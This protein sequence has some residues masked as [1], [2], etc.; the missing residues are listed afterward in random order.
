MGII[1]FATLGRNPGAITAGLSYLFH[2]RERFSTVYAGQLVEA[3]VLFGPGTGIYTEPCKF[4]DY[5]QKHRLVQP[6]AE[7]RSYPSTPPIDVIHHV[8]QNIAPQ[9]QTISLYSYPV[10]P[11][12]FNAC[13]DTM[14][15]ALIAIS[16]AQ[17]DDPG[18]TVW[19]NLTGGTNIMNAAG[20]QLAALSGLI[21]RVYYTFVSN[22]S[23]RMFLQPF[24]S[25]PNHFRWEEIEIYKTRYDESY[26]HL[27]DIL[28]KQD[29]WVDLEELLMTYQQ[30]PIAQSTYEKVSADH[31]RTLL[32][33]RMDGREIERDG[34]QIRLGQ[35]GRE[36]LARI[37]TQS[38][39][40][41]LQQK[42]GITL[43][44]AP[45]RLRLEQNLLF[46]VNQ[47]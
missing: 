37:Q 15:Q 47:P 39:Q 7:W 1:H 3:L 12:D 23:D 41:I 40:V 14:A 27:L 29:R 16:T 18:Q 10:D 13:L 5:G 26:Y 34:N 6:G 22:E 24:T 2:N 42:Q 4:N 17:P 8:L 28:E 36:T 20:M 19:L 11:D 46:Q 30:D 43:D 38:L 33:H 45:Y 21:D 35:K 9:T 44:I 25:D 31:L 32:L